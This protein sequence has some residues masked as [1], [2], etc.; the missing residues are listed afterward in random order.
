MKSF[1]FAKIVFTEFTWNRPK[2]FRLKVRRGYFIGQKIA[3]SPLK[4]PVILMMS[5]W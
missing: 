3:M 2:A 5:G 1:P 4:K